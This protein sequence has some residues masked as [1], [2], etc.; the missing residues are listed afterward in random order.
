MTVSWKVRVLDAVRR[1][2]GGGVA[3]MSLDEIRR[4]RRSR[5]PDLPFGDELLDPLARRLFG[6]PRSD[7]R[8]D[9]GT[10][11]GAEGDLSA[12][13]Y[14]PPAV[15]S[16]DPLILYLH[17]GGWTTGSPPLYDWLCSRLAAGVGATVVSADYRKAPEHP[18][19]AAVEDAVAAFEWLAG[20]PEQIGATGP[21]A[22]AGDS[23]GGNLAAL[24]AIAARDRDLDLAAQILIYPGIDLTQSFPSMQHMT[25]APLLPRDDVDAFLA[26]YLSGGIAPDDPR[27]S[28]WFVE[29]VSG[30]APALVQTAQ[31]DPL[32]DEGEAYA[33]KLEKAG[34][35]VRLTR[36]VDVPHGFVSVPGIA[37]AAHQAVSEIARF[38]EDRL[39]R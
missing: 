25:D 33:R 1:G 15:A 39:V 7:V 4:A 34:V 5:L 35:E 32:V 22:V 36:Y 17:G 14:S 27:V 30:V 23:A 3:S 28:P 19:P 38:L 26:H 11:P 2:L 18:A 16:P 20:N 13:I 37:P 31:H 12:R 8:V 6:A 10:V 24:V 9:T 29:D 21:I